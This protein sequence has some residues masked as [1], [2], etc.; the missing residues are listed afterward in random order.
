MSEKKKTLSQLAVE[1]GVSREAM[2]KRLKR[3]GQ[4][5]LPDPNN[6]S[7]NRGDSKYTYQGETAKHWAKLYNVTEWRV[8][9]SI[10]RGEKLEEV[11][12]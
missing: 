3:N 10:K 1:H 12:G 8:V 9:E 5:D 2:R 7:H 4:P 6:I 11:Y